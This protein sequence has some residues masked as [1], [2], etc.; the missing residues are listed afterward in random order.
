MV[1]FSGGGVALRNIA[2][3]L[4]GTTF[5][6]PSE[7]WCLDCMYSHEGN[8]WGSWSRKTGKQLRVGLTS[9]ESTGL[10]RGQ[11]RNV[12]ER[13]EDLDRPFRL[14]A[15]GAAQ[16]VHQE[17]VGGCAEPVRHTA[18]G[19]PVRPTPATAAL[20]G[21]RDRRCVVAVCAGYRLLCLSN[22]R[23]SA[24]VTGIRMEGSLEQIFHKQGFKL[25]RGPFA[26][27]AT[28]TCLMQ[29]GPDDGV[30]H[31]AN[32][33]RARSDLCRDRNGVP[34]RRLEGRSRYALRATAP[35]WPANRARHVRRSRLV[36]LRRPI[37]SWARSAGSRDRLSARAPAR[38]ASRGCAEPA[39]TIPVK[40]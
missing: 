14:R 5:S 31:P 29:P 10:Q 18:P 34:L 39:A 9:G 27:A 21:G 8:E 30:H 40:A 28:R 17:L 19:S 20:G 37:R 16:T 32:H 2:L 25:S 23:H 35:L 3:K 38:G 4:S 24:R 13:R 7:V 33:L 1:G 11:E 6:L 22:V 36:P 15:R 12:G 26:A